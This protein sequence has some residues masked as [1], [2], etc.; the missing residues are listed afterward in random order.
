MRKWFWVVA[1]LCVVS[2]ATGVFLYVEKKQDLPA[3]QEMKRI[4][5]IMPHNDKIY[6][7]KIAAGAVDAANE[8]GV[9]LKLDYSASNYS[10]EQ[11]TE[12]IY[13]AIASRVD[14]IITQGNVNEGFV[15]A[16]NKAK[17]EGIAVVLVDTDCE[18]INRDLYVGTENYEA[19]RKLGEAIASRMDGKAVIGIITA[20]EDFPNL[21]ERRQGLEGVCKQY[22]DMK[23][24]RIESDNYDAISAVEVYESMLKDNPE[25]DT[26]VCL[27]G[28][29]IYAL[30][31]IL[32]D[33]GN[34]GIR[35]F[36]FDLTDGWED[37]LRQR[38]VEG[39]LG[40]E[41]YEM[42]YSCIKELSDFI[43]TGIIS[44]DTIYTK[45]DLITADNIDEYLEEIKNEE[46]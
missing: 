25:I 14:A 5:F 43:Q 16:L 19:G 26:I 28:T 40:Q 32:L 15:E 21:L 30:N 13:V 44:E 35:I 33:K 39:I 46:K 36:G 12:L 10:V 8:F 45:T 41:T 9:D 31:P 11:M 6:W 23:I 34:S 24:A 1:A 18:E 17:E 20:N 3:P 4:T 7:K 27:E 42:G 29:G 2:L 38:V 37:A 22:P